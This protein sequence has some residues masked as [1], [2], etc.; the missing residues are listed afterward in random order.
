MLVPVKLPGWI[1][2]CLILLSMLF[3]WHAA[4]SRHE[5]ANS[6]IPRLL[7]LE[8]QCTT[9]SGTHPDNLVLFTYTEYRAKTV[10]QAL[11]EHPEISKQFGTI[12]AYWQADE[13]EVVQL[14]GKGI[15][16]LALVKDNFVKAL[17]SDLTY[18]YE[19]VG[20]YEDYSAYFISL[21]EKPWLTKEYL[22]GK[23]IGLLD[24]PTSRSG[25]IIPMRMF[26]DLGLTRDQINIV[27]AKSH[28]ELRKFLSN[29]NVDII[30]SYWQKKDEERFSKNYITPLQDDISGSKWYLKLKERNTELRC[31]VQDILKDLTEKQQGYYQN[32]TILN[33][34]KSD[35][36]NQ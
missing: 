10:M 9:Q 26:K 6:S 21:K 23:R 27:Y 34:C 32:L 30:S 11:C 19:V 15:V 25:H 13:R 20:A 24:Y 22:L 14:I 5:L 33:P 4:Q 29:G 2:L 35:E 28:S 8:S 16:D 12:T 17:Q 36:V 31:S 7:E 18:G 3:L 1:F